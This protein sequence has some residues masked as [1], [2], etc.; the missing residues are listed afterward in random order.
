MKKF[1]KLFHTATTSYHIMCSHNVTLRD[2]TSLVVA[3]TSEKICDANFFLLLF[4]LFVVQSAPFVLYLSRFFFVFIRSRW[5]FKKF[6]KYFLLCKKYFINFLKKVFYVRKK[7]FYCVKKFFS[8]KKLFF[9]PKFFF[10]YGK[11][12]FRRKGQLFFNQH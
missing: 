9:F 2:D 10:S 12:N 7:I 5:G 4:F 11:K 8:F 6:Y 3:P 1:F